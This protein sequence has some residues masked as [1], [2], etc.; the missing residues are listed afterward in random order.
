MFTILT[1]NLEEISNQI[2]VKVKL[3]TAVL[4]YK[5][6]NT[7]Q[8]SHNSLKGAIMTYESTE[9]HIQ[10]LPIKEKSKRNRRRKKHKEQVTVAPDFDVPLSQDSPN[11]DYERKV[12]KKKKKKKK[13]KYKSD[14]K[15]ID[16]KEEPGP[17]LDFHRRKLIEAAM[18]THETTSK[19]KKKKKGGDQEIPEHLDIHARDHAQGVKVEASIHTDNSTDQCM[20]VLGTNVAQGVTV[21]NNKKKANK[22]KKRQEERER[23][24]KKHVNICPTWCDPLPKNKKRKLSDMNEE[25]NYTLKTNNEVEKRP[26]IDDK[27]PPTSIEKDAGVKRKR[28]RG[29]KKRVKDEP[30][31]EAQTQHFE[32]QN[33]IFLSRTDTNSNS[34]DY[35]ETDYADPLEDADPTEGEFFLTGDEVADDDISEF[36]DEEEKGIKKLLSRNNDALAM[37]KSTTN[38]CKRLKEIVPQACLNL[39]SKPTNQDDKENMLNKLFEWPDISKSKF[40]ILYKV[41]DWIFTKESFVVPGKCF[42]KYEFIVKKNFNLHHFRSQRRFEFLFQAR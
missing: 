32:L 3:E 9:Y 36:M 21:T 26:R 38:I 35:D 42:P 33:E 39:R 1:L 30:I 24:K 20:E 22:K 27:S 11:K 31:A 16:P 13:N 17:D 23:L 4:Q 2:K 10:E 5:C 18:T 12:K 34:F 8:S 15:L 25:V 19:R 6:F 40:P 41:M 37:L 28:Q 7:S 14:E 29:K